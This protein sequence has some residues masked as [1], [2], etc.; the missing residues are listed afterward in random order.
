MTRG[1][2]DSGNGKPSWTYFTICVEDTKGKQRQLLKDNFTLVLRLYDTSNK[3]MIAH[4]KLMYRGELESAEDQT[5]LLAGACDRGARDATH[6]GSCHVAFT[7]YAGSGDSTK[8]SASSFASL[9]PFHSGHGDHGRRRRIY[10]RQARSGRT[11][12]P[13]GIRC[14]SEAAVDVQGPV[15]L[16]WRP[17]D[18][19]DLPLVPAG[20]ERSWRM[21]VGVAHLQF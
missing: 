7:R 18:L 12:V 8:S 15:R 19:C 1:I 13:Q 5:S 3:L 21:A 17:H 14:V 4:R 2:L 11:R 20:D 6:P 16:A 9:P 10:P